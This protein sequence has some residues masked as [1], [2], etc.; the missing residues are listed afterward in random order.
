MLDASK[1]LRPM[2]RSPSWASR[3]RSSI[4]SSEYISH[5]PSRLPGVR[6]ATKLSGQRS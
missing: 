6:R 4:R 5:S 1:K 2:Q 3:M